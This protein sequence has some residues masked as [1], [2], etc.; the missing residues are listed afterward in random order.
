MTFRR[1]APTALLALVCACRAER[2]VAEVEIALAS[3]EV[4]ES[5]ASL[6]VFAILEGEVVASA[7]VPPTRPS[8]LLG[9]PA[10]EPIEF[11]VVARTDRPG[12]PSIGNMPAYAGMVVK[13]VPLGIEPERVAITAHRAGVL[14]VLGVPMAEE[15][16]SEPV[17]VRFQEERGEGHVEITFPPEPLVYERHLILRATRWRASVP[18]EE[19]EESPR[20]FVDARGS[21]L[22]EAERQSLYPVGIVPA[23]EQPASDLRLSIALLDEGLGV[24]E[25]P[26]RVRTPDR[27]AARLSVLIAAIDPE[28][29]SV[30]LPEAI[31]RW[32]IVSIPEGTVSGP[33]GET[34]GEVM[35][36]P[37]TLEGFS[38]RGTGR[39]AIEARIEG[40][41]ISPP[42][43]AVHFDVLAPGVTP[44]P[45]ASVALRLSD[46]TRLRQGTDLAIEIVD[47][48]GLLVDRYEGRVDLGTSDPWIDLPEGP[49]SGLDLEDRGHLR[50][51]VSRPSGPPSLQVSLHA[52]ATSTTG[53]TLTATLA[54]PPI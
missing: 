52:I 38:G 24:L 47:A 54:I 34:S 20:F 14:T 1:A 5:V 25:A 7:T 50:R 39:A 29:E 49:L 33:N 28:G 46:P 15:L 13:T 45:P 35:G 8:V 23:P 16:R 42:R 27:G 32:S 48:M 10:E 21:I 36:L 40:D 2:P 18:I 44:G 12:P 43:G 6:S 41:P 3:E 9:V 31:A 53:L 4:P 19:G 22:V 37:A 26:D 51:T 17:T 11:H 30:D